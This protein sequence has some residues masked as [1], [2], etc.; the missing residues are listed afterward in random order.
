MSNCWIDGIIYL[1]HAMYV[2]KSHEVIHDCQHIFFPQ[3]ITVF[4]CIIGK[5]RGSF[6]RREKIFFLIIQCH[7]NHF[8]SFVKKM[9]YCSHFCLHSFK[10]TCSSFYNDGDFSIRNVVQYFHHVH[11]TNVLRIVTRPSIQQIEVSLEVA[12]LA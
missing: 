1:I 6:N 2:F 8:S 9:K 7:L 11:R 5:S 12:H 4:V 10:I 3:L